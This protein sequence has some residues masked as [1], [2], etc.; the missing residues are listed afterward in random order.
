II[1]HTG[2]STRPLADK[3]KVRK[4]ADLAIQAV[5]AGYQA[6]ESRVD[7]PA[8]TAV[9]KAVNV[10]ED[11]G[12]VNAGVGAVKQWDG[13]QRR[14]ATIM[15][16]STLSCGAVSSLE[17]IKNAI[18]VARRLMEY[19][20][21]PGDESKDPKWNFHFC[22]YFIEEIFGIHGER[23]PDGWKM[24]GRQCPSR[25]PA[26]LSEE[27]TVGAVAIDAAGNIAAGTSTGGLAGSYPGRIGDSPVIGAGTYAN[28]SC[29]VSNTGRGE[30]VIKLCCA[31][32]V[33][34]LV[35]DQGI[36]A[37]LAVDRM[38][39][40]YEA[41]LPGTTGRI[42]TIAIDKDGNWT[43]NFN[44]AAMTW[45]VKTRDRGFYGQQPGEK[46]EF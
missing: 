12:L 14:D 36:N 24:P 23:V 17:G 44:G 7:R 11:S 22:G 9:E 20:E 5:D 18:S 13:V 34:D 6:L 27:G 2:V 37:M 30:N 42:G 1:I 10:L 3:E 21:L 45:A 25:V 41:A 29:G 40:E 26:P 33:C 15:D 4:L 16:G 46:V 39:K 32:R 31:K 8:V 43:S 38:I 35:Q 19:T 28:R